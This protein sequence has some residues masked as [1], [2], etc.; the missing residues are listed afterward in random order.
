M[1]LRERIGSTMS[2]WFDITFML[3]SGINK[4]KPNGVLKQNNF[5]LWLEIFLI[6]VK[7]YFDVILN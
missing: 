5:N 4:K 7:W 3:K 2:I 1:S 6:T